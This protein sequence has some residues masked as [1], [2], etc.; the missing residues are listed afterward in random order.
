MKST[1]DLSTIGDGR[2]HIALE[3]CGRAT[4]QYVARF[5]SEWIGCAATESGAREQADLHYR[6][7]MIRLGLK[8]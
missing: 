4:R 5:C 1:D 6:A 2:Y 8:L 7:M 3:W